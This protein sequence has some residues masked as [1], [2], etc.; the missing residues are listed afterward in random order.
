MRPTYG[1]NYH[2][3]FL[4]GS[5]PGSVHAHH[6]LFRTCAIEYRSDD[7]TK[8]ILFIFLHFSLLNT[9]YRWSMIKKQNK[10][11]K[12]KTKTKTKTKQTDKKQK[13]KKH[14]PN[15]VEIGSWGP[16]I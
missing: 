6:G 11:Q 2:G 10:K 15:L 14:S 7:V 3:N 1:N 5:L 12:Q 9:I 16:K 4:P 13:R 8:N